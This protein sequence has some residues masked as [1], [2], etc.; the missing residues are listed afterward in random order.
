MSH[1]ESFQKSASGNFSIA[2]LMSCTVLMAYRVSASRSFFNAEP[3][4][5]IAPA[6][7][8]CGAGPDLEPPGAVPGRAID[9]VFGS[10]RI[11]K[12]G[13]PFLSRHVNQHAT[14]RTRAQRSERDGVQRLPFG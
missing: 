1:S 11:A 3:L 7:E 12:T 6:A 8:D 5:I 10:L 4:A 13:L 14:H 2:F 9:A